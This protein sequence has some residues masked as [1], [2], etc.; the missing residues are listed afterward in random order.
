ME[1]MV[2]ADNK[3]YKL[4]EHVIPE[5]TDLETIQAKIK[6]A[7][8]EEFVGEQIRKIS[9]EEAESKR[10]TIRQTQ[11]NHIID[12]DS[13]NV[14][15]VIDPLSVNINE[16]GDSLIELIS[17]IEN[18][19]LDKEIND[20]THEGAEQK[21]VNKLNKI[22][23]LAQR[24]G[25]YITD[26]AKQFTKE[27]ETLICYYKEEKSKTVEKLLSEQRSR[28]VLDE[29]YKDSLHK[30]EKLELMLKNQDNSKGN[31][32]EKL[33]QALRQIE[34]LENIVQ[35]EQ[36]LRKQA[37]LRTKEILIKAKKLKNLSDN[38]KKQREIAE[39][40]AQKAVTR[41][42]E[43]MS[44]FFNSAFVEDNIGRSATGFINNTFPEFDSMMISKKF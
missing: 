5:P 18:N 44:Y 30:I 25:M 17:D 32:E 31:L 42:R 16:S 36:E 20:I 7:E 22:G 41:A 27:L 1:K 11:F 2:N 29:D 43:V 37:D 9:L 13:N 3:K 19:E 39:K 15:Q 33:Q 8:V 24:Q 34:K 35:T 21:V 6:E 28:L 4:V 26:V 12:N 40:Q 38:D 10:A 14:E 23:I